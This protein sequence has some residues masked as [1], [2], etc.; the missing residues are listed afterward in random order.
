[1]RDDGFLIC[2]RGGMSLT[3]LRVRLPLCGLRQESAETGGKLR[4]ESVSAARKREV[5]D[6]KMSKVSQPVKEGA[7]S[8]SIVDACWAIPRKM[9][10]GK[11]DAKA[12]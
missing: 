5:G 3:P 10:D 8:K 6:R 1:M 2:R 11:K 7:L 12:C 9:V 4:G